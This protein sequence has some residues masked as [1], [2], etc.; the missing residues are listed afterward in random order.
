M[1]GGGAYEAKGVHRQGARGVGQEAEAKDVEEAQGRDKVPQEVAGGHGLDEARGAVVGPDALLPVH[2]AALVIVPHD[3]EGQEVDKGALDDGHDVRVPVDLF[4]PR[5]P[6]VVAREPP[7]RHDGRHDE[8]DEGVEE[9]GREHLVD[10]QRQR[11]HAEAV[12]PWLDGRA[13]RRDGRKRER[14]PHGFRLS[15]CVRVAVGRSDGRSVWKWRALQKLTRE[16]S[17]FRTRPQLYR[18]PGCRGYPG[19]QG[20]A[21]HRWQW[22]V[23]GV[24]EGRDSWRL[25]PGTPLDGVKSQA[26]DGTVKRE[27]SFSLGPKQG[28]GYGRQ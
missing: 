11:V 15:V 24:W 25:S 22:A 19:S 17:G 3:V 2:L 21:G 18:V 16:P 8:V 1:G 6:R 26:H 20:E 27:L 7:C 4:R 14:I 9:R 12:G 23:G 5:V 10:V 13:E 28:S